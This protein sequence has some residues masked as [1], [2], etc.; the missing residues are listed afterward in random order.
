MTYLLD[1]PSMEDKSL[2]AI[3]KRCIVRIYIAT[4]TKSERRYRKKNH[5]T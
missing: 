4:H 3:L 2:R 1:I 5:I